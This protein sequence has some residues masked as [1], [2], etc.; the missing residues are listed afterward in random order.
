MEA[1]APDSSELS[2]AKLH[3][4]LDPDKR[5]FLENYFSVIKTA[6]TAPPSLKDAI[7]KVVA[8]EPR[9]HMVRYFLALAETSISVETIRSLKFPGLMKK[10][11]LRLKGKYHQSNYHLESSEGI[12]ANSY[13]RQINTQLAQEFGSELRLYSLLKMYTK[14]LTF[15]EVT[16]ARDA[17]LAVLT[18]CVLLV[19]SGLEINPFV[20]AFGVYSVAQ[21]GLVMAQWEARG[22]LARPIDTLIERLQKKEITFDLEQYLKDS[23]LFT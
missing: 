12:V 14:E 10:V 4:H 3:D 1:S 22:R 21:I 17:L 2:R 18:T 20:G 9:Q 23:D 7:A 11:A 6:E 15:N 8:A 16:H 19:I 13:Q 5:K